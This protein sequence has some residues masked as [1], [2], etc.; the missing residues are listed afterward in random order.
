MEKSK[1]Y[2]YAGRLLS[3]LNDNLGWT[4]EELKQ[5]SQ[6]SEL[7]LEITIRLMVK[8]KMITKDSDQVIPKYY[9]QIIYYYSEQE[10]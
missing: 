10:L 6:L 8:A 5:E 2:T 7:E 3:I 4:Y 9:P 1:F